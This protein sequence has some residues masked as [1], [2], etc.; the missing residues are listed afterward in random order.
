MTSHASSA[1]NSSCH[2][3]G[4]QNGHASACRSTFLEQSSVWNHFT[5]GSS[6]NG[7]APRRPANGDRT[8]QQRSRKPAQKVPQIVQKQVE[9]NAARPPRRSHSSIAVRPP[10]D[11]KCFPL[12]VQMLA[13]PFSPYQSSFTTPTAIAPHRRTRGHLLI[14]L[15]LL[16]GQIL[17][18]LAVLV[19]AP[20]R[21]PRPHRLLQQGRRPPPASAR[22]MHHARDAEPRR[23]PQ[24]WPAAPPA[25][26]GRS[27]RPGCA[28]R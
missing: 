9:R 23:R 11:Q 28:A 26:A 16:P 24:R 13:L 20:G 25:P 27:P 1:S 21:Q 17:C 18:G 2:R 6:T 12:A 4:Q 8:P 10:V 7:H 15:L 19:N 3:I 14:F 22:P 5:I